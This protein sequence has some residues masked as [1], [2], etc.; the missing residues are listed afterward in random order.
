MLIVD[1]LTLLGREFLR[2]L[3]NATDVYLEVDY[4]HTAADDEHQITELAAEPA[5]VPP[6]EGPEELTNAGVVVITSDQETERTGHLEELMIRHPE[7]AVVDVGRLPRL[8]DHTYPATGGTAGTSERRHLR[9]AQPTLAATAAVL[10][11]LGPLRPTR[12]T[13]AAVDPVSIHGREAIDTLV[14]QAGRRMQGGTPDHLID[15]QVLAFSQVAMGAD[16]FMEEASEVVPDI[17][18]AVSRTAV[19]CFHGHVVH[20]GVEFG[21]PVD[22]P[23]LRELIESRPEILLCDTPLS[24]D[25]V[26]DQDQILLAQPQLSPDRRMAAMTVMVDGLRIGGALTALDI[27]RTMI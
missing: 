11:A 16:A 22:D 23:E 1:P 15:G 14:H 6:L 18:L 19:G 3:E 2:C 5:L 13:V 12:G 7:I 26:P 24:L 8:R 21:E 17:P 10:E 20:L 27:I 9:T 4:R 25:S